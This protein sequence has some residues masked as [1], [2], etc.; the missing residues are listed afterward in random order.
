MDCWEQVRLAAA[1][2]YQ[3]YPVLGVKQISHLSQ[4]SLRLSSVRQSLFAEIQDSVNIIWRVKAKPKRGWLNFLKNRLLS[5]S[6]IVSLGFVLI[7]SLIVNGA[8]QV[9]SERLW[10]FLLSLCWLACG[11]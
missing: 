6:L 3:E 4:A 8:I 1:G 2:N 10:L 9:L 5:M 7:V 11:N